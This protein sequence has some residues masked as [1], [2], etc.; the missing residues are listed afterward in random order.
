[1][2]FCRVEARASQLWEINRALSDGCMAG[3]PDNPS[4][5][6]KLSQEW[7]VAALREVVAADL[8][9]MERP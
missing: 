5:L 1:M 7:I 2:P 3:D 9:T 6:V 8:V 4:G